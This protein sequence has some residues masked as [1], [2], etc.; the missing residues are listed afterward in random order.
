MRFLELHRG[1]RLAIPLGCNHGISFK[2]T[3]ESLQGQGLIDEG[4]VMGPEN[5]VNS[6]LHKRAVLSYCWCFELKKSIPDL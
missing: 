4:V 5:R 1:N 6:F 2:K 3:E